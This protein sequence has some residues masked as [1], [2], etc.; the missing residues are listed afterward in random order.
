MNRQLFQQIVTDLN[1]IIRKEIT[2]F[3]AYH[4]GK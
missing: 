4:F 3:Y 2:Q 1:G